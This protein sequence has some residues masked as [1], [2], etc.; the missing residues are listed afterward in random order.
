ME[1]DCRVAVKKGLTL[2]FSLAVFS[3]THSRHFLWGRGW[4]YGWEGKAGSKPSVP[5]LTLKFTQF[6]SC[7][8]STSLH[9]SV[10]KI[11]TCD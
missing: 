11:T 5:S 7:C 3:H 6:V 2:L 9:S 8:L 4:W 1:P 10:S